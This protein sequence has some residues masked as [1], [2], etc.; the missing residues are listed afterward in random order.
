MIESGKQKM[1]WLNY[2]HLYYFREIAKEGSISKASEKLLVGQPSLSH[3]LKQLEE[4]LGTSLFERKKRSL[5]LTPQGEVALRYADEIFSKGEEFQRAFS[6]GSFYDQNSY[7]LGALAGLSKSFVCDLLDLV[8]HRDPA[9]FISTFEAELD[10]LIERLERFE[11]DLAVTDDPGDDRPGLYR[12]MVGKSRVCVYGSKEFAHLQKDFPA[13]LEGMP[14]L[15]RA[16]RSK[17][18]FDVEHFYSSRGL[19]YELAAQCQDSSVKEA[20]AKRGRGLV[21]LSER[22]GKELEESGSLIKIGEL[23]GV[24]EELWLLSANRLINN[25]NTQYIFKEFEVER[26]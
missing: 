25:P 23:D 6:S 12:R 26:M 21:F 20:L 11:I 22:A 10:E 16:S 5:S 19:R 3:Q 1:K 17:L 13:S 24:A 15:L 2:H 7:R 9:C 4:S 18:R 8:K 14:V